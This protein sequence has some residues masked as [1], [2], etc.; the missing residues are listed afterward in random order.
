MT[1]AKEFF[2]HLQRTFPR[3]GLAKMF[4]TLCLKMPNGKSAAML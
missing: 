1:Q 2:E 4:G 3:Q